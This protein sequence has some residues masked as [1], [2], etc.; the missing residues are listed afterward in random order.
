MTAYRELE[1]ALAAAKE[2]IAKK[3]NAN[4]DL[5]SRCKYLEE[6]IEKVRELLRGA[7]MDYQKARGEV[8]WLRN[9]NLWE[10]I[11]NKT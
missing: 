6:E 5:K 7:T 10:R 3:D 4:A 8:L 9:R 1:T 2:S 11:V